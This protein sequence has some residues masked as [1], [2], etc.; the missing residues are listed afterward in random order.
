LTPRRTWPLVAGVSSE[1][2][3]EE[4]EATPM[5]TP[6]RKPLSLPRLFL[7]FLAVPVAMFYV[8]ITPGAWK[9]LTIAL[10]FAVLGYMAIA[11]GRDSRDGKDW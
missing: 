5:S 7:A 2:E 8:S 4:E 10:A 1:E 3:E 9:F 6:R 11:F